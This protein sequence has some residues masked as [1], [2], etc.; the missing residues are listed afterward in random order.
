VGDADA[1]LEPGDDQGVAHADRP[2][3]RGPAT[4][5]RDVAAE[6]DQYAAAR[7]DVA[8][9]EIH[10]ERLGARAQVDLTPGSETRPTFLEVQSDRA[11]PEARDGLARR[12]IRTVRELGKVHVVPEGHQ[13]GQHGR[14]AHSVG[15]LEGVE[16][17]AQRQLE[18]RT[19]RDVA[20]SI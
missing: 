12:S 18:G 15:R 2:W 10:D 14:V 1:R 5:D 3:T 19:Q 20:V 9:D 11:G 13:C 17:C 6:F 7:G 16:C 8:S 4:V